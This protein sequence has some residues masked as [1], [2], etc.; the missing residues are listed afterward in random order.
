MPFIATVLSNRNISEKTKL[1]KLIWFIDYSKLCNVYV[2]P[3]LISSASHHSYQRPAQNTVA[4]A[5]HFAE[6]VNQ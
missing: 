5:T 6:S 4:H 3:V 2:V 1:T